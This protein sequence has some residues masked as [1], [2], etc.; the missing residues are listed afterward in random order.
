MDPRLR[1]ALD[2]RLRRALDRRLRRAM[3][4][5]LRLILRMDG[6][7]PP[8]IRI[9]ATATVVTPGTKMPTAD[10]AGSNCRDAHFCRNDFSSCKIVMHFVISCSQAI[11]F[12]VS[13]HGSKTVLP[14]VS[15]RRDLSS[16]PWELLDSVAVA[17]F[18]EVC[19]FGPE[20][21]PSAHVR[22]CGPS[23]RMLPGPCIL[24]SCSLCCRLDLIPQLDML[25]FKA[26]SRPGACEHY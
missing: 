2:P 11:S 3:D 26:S 4:P 13:L 25:I 24:Q 14:G 5:G 18:A 21:Q 19:S 17:L 23:C 15:R 16:A 12:D 9:T 1:R 8:G 10:G 20:Q 22:F 7:R 6:V